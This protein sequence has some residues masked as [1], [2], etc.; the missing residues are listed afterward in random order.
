MTVIVDQDDAKAAG[1]ILAQQRTDRPADDAGLIARWHH[2]NHRRPGWGRLAVRRQA[3][4]SLGLKQARLFQPEMPPEGQQV[5]PDTD[6]QTGKNDPKLHHDRS[7]SGLDGWTPPK[8][9]GRR[10]TALGP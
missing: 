9:R 4:G 2:G 1:I 7:Y 3:L 10:N 8:S 5:N 6:R